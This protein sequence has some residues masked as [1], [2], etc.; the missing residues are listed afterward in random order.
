MGQSPITRD[1]MEPV[2]HTAKIFLGFPAIRKNPAY[3]I[4]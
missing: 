3:Q 4:M 1:L 2:W